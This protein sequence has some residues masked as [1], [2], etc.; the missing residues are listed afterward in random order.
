L[1][2][3]KVLEDDKIFVLVHIVAEYEI[4]VGFVNAATATLLN[5]DFS[6]RFSFNMINLEDKEDHDRMGAWMTQ[7]LAGHSSHQ[8]AEKSFVGFIYGTGGPTAC[9]QY[10]HESQGESS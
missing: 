8:E 3:I 5:S 4:I 1:R 6:T 9:D 10:D 7:E 2:C